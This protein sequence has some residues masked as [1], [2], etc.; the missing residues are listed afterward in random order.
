MGNSF[1]KKD[2]YESRNYEILHQFR[3][4]KFLQKALKQANIKFLELYQLECEVPTSCR[5]SFFNAW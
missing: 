1:L 3:R 2:F 5:L 4:I